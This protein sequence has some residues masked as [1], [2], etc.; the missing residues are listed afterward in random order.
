MATRPPAPPPPGG[1]LPLVKP[2]PPAAV[3][4][5]AVSHAV[6]E[7]EPTTVGAL[8][9][10]LP[11][12]PP[13]PSIALPPLASIHP[14]STRPPSH[15]TETLPPPRPGFSPFPSPPCAV[16]CVSWPQPAAF[17]ACVVLSL[18][19]TAPVPPFPPPALLPDALAVDGA[20]VPRAVTLTDEFVESVHVFL[21]YSSM[22][23][24][25]ICAVMFK[26][27]ELLTCIDI[28]HGCGACAFDAPF[29]SSSSFESE[30]SMTVLFPMVSVPF[31]T[32][33]VPDASVT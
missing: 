13:P 9:T 22:V 1:F 31:P 19:H 26:M 6:V 32:T 29:S 33:R 14:A 7:G 4:A 30:Q 21:A 16:G 8:T 28:S 20:S 3:I 15:V 24:P 11:P 25:L 27:M 17:P 5:P 23:D 10:M 2:S 12:A 18:L